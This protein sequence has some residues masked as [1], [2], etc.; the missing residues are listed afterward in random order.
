MHFWIKYLNIHHKQTIIFTFQSWCK[1][2]K[3]RCSYPHLP[4]RQTHKESTDFLC[5]MLSSFRT[6]KK[7]KKS[8]PDHCRTSV[9]IFLLLTPP[10]I[11]SRVAHTRSLSKVHTVSVRRLPLPTTVT[12][13]SI[14][15]THFDLWL[16]YSPLLFPPDCL[17]EFSL[18]LSN[19]FTSGVDRGGQRSSLPCCKTT[20]QA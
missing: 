6:L 12:P 9:K 7:K 17:G 18:S 8:W 19:G 13:G 3:T 10:S 16:F 11:L 5:V 4:Q 2:C 1:I 15:K 14:P 20:H